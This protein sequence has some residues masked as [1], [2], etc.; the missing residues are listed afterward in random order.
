MLSHFV[1]VLPSRVPIELNCSYSFH[2]VKLETKEVNCVS[3]TSLI[4]SKEQHWQTRH[5]SLCSGCLETQHMDTHSHTIDQLVNHRP[6]R[7]ASGHQPSSYCVRWPLG[8]VV[9]SWGLSPTQKDSLMYSP[10]TV[11]LPPAPLWKDTWQAYPQMGQARGRGRTHVYGCVLSWQRSTSGG[12]RLKQWR[13]WKAGVVPELRG[14]RLL[15]E[16]VPGS[17]GLDDA[18][19]R[20]VEGTQGTEG[21]CVRGCRGPEVCRP[22]TQSLPHAPVSSQLFKSVSSTMPNRYTLCVCC[23]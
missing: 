4:P 5:A 13:W 23:V 18:V 6:M 14:K 12:N 19:T 1:S 3:L 2:C 7:I 17:I 9:S 8:S 10:Y 22:L 11:A 20:G 15:D 21:G 16:L